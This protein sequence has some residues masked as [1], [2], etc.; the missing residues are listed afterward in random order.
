MRA[1]TQ[2]HTL[3]E[4]KEA[5]RENRW[6]EEAKEDGATDEFEAGVLSLRTKFLPDVVQRVLKITENQ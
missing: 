1:N 5:G 4:M 6:T 3:A 2:T